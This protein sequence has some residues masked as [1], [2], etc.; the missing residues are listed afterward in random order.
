MMRW[1]NCISQFSSQKTL[2]SSSAV[3]EHSVSNTERTFALFFQFS[4]FNFSCFNDALPVFQSLM[5]SFLL[6]NDIQLY[7]NHFLLWYTAA[8]ES[9]LV[10]LQYTAVPESFLATIYGCISIISCVATIYSCTGI[11]SCLATIYSCIRIVSWILLKMIYGCTRII[12]CYNIQLYRNHF[13][14]C[15]NIQLYRNHVSLWLILL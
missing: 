2:H 9:F 15:Y 7:W 3:A 10:F 1:V 13:F 11:I 14:F 4:D 6:Q 12:S 8:P 5:T